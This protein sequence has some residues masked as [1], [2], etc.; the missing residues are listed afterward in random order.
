VRG[1]LTEMAE[2]AATGE[3]S[4][5][6]VNNARTCLSM[7]LGEAVRRR[8]LPVSACRYVPELPV[9]RTEID[10]PAFGRDRPLPRRVRRPLPSVGR[11]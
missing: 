5:K 11:A 8:R 7:T 10:Y 3:L 4:A 1:W 2:L 6:T 9:E